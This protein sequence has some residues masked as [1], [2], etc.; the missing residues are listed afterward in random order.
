VQYAQQFCQANLEQAQNQHDAGIDGG[1]SCKQDKVRPVK[2]GRAV[3]DFAKGERAEAG[4][5]L[6]S[7]KF[8]DERLPGY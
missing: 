1:D 6:E 3:K 2:L 8:G 7:S 4:F 5:H